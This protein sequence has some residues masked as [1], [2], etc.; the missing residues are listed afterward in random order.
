MFCLIP[1]CNCNV[2]GSLSLE[3]NALGACTCKRNVQG[4]K[5]DQCKPGFFGLQQNNLGGC[6]GTEE[7]S[8]RIHKRYCIV[9]LNS[10]QRV[11]CA[12]NLVLMEETV[13]VMLLTDLASANKT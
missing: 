8:Y 9:G 2:T 12:T 10:V 1:A 11:C 4:L 5:C 6:Q 3:C 13:R 7:S